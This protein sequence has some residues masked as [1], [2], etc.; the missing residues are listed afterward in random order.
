MLEKGMIENP[1]MWH[2]VIE[3]GRD[4]LHAAFYSLLDDHDI[5]NASFRFNPEKPLLPQI[6][7]TVYA[8]PLLLDDFPVATIICDSP[9]FQ[10]LPEFVSDDETAAMAF[11]AAMP[12]Q[13]EQGETEIIVND[14]PSV[15]ARLAFEVPTDILGLIRRTFNNTPVNHPCEI[16]VKYFSHKYTSRSRGKTIAN[17]RERRLDLLTLGESTPMMLSSYEVREPMD[18][19]YYILAA[20][21]LLNL[22][23]SDEILIAGN[24]EMRSAISPVLRR[25][26]QF[27][28]PAIPPAAML[29]GDRS[30]LGL[31]FEMAVAPIITRSAI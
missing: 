12:E 1:A 19:A 29:R 6:E 21:K 23:E 22:K 28:L 26:A 24:R 13:P 31:P 2:P 25:Y 8:N 11:R 15:A 27:V 7:E 4:T 3:I 16:L 18:A 10:L 14:L 5:I 17:L 20:R 30:A 9:R